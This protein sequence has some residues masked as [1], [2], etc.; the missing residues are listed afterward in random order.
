MEVYDVGME[1]CALAGAAQHGP[2]RVTPG[3]FVR[4]RHGF[5]RSSRPVA[6]H[7]VRAKLYGAC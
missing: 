6:A 3:A 5:S 1:F 7:C 2:L 4:Y